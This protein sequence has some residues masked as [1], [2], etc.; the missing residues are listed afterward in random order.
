MVVVLGESSC[1]PNA[2]GDHV[3]AF[4]AGFASPSTSNGEGPLW[5]EGL[6]AN[7]TSGMQGRRATPITRLDLHTVQAV[8][9]SA[10]SNMERSDELRR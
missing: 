9:R 1:S 2:P 4:D 10:S 3:L 6:R 5:C 8:R 7:V